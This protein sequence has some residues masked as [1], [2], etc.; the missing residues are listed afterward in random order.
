MSSPMAYMQIK[1]IAKRYGTYGLVGAAAD[2]GIAER[3]SS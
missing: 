2:I 3:S 1:G